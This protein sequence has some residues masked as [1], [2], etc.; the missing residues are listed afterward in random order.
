MD[1]GEGNERTGRHRAEEPRQWDHNARVSEVR[2]R[3]EG[4]D[5]FKKSVY[6]DDGQ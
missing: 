6:T 5:D 4:I 2:A 3:A 1:D